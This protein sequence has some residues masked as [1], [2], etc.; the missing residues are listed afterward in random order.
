MSI[1]KATPTLREYLLEHGH[2]SDELYP[3]FI[4]LLDDEPVP[5]IQRPKEWHDAISRFILKHYGN[6]FFPQG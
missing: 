6:R 1:P 4:F 2:Y 5:P 3:E